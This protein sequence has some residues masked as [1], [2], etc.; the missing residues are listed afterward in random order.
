MAKSDDFRATSSCAISR[1]C[2]RQIAALERAVGGPVFDRP[3][4]PSPV[5]L[6][7]LGSLHRQA[8]RVHS[9]LA[10]RTVHTAVAVELAP[11]P[12]TARPEP[13]AP[14]RAQRWL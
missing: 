1:R 6:T 7:P 12:T 13:V 5:R 14:R 10:A 2:S 4:G 9:P 8:G 3:G 11:P